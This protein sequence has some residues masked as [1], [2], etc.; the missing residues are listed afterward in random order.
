MSENRQ[1]GGEDALGGSHCHACVE[2]LVCLEAGVLKA[3]PTTS[4]EKVISAL[5]LVCCLGESAPGGKLLNPPFTSNIN[6][7]A[8]IVVLQ[9]SGLL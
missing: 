2:L 1:R 9:S 8:L 3:V 6:I 7:P 5:H 4:G